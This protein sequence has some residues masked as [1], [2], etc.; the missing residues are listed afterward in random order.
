MWAINPSV[1][2][3]HAWE[4]TNSKY[5][6]TALVMFYLFVWLGILKAVWG[7]INPGFLGQLHCYLPDLEGYEASFVTAM[8]RGLCLF[9]LAF[10]VYADKGGLHSWNVGFVT[11]FVLMWI[12]IAQSSMI[13]PMDDHTFHKCIGKW[14]HSMWVTPVWIVLAFLLTLMDE[15][16]GDDSTAA[17]RQPLA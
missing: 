2:L 5:G 8:M 14:W 11:F 10:L 15:R 9:T 12:W 16:Q 13:K 7:L 4:K 6:K 17:E 1:Y 3:N